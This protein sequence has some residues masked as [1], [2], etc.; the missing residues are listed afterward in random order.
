MHIHMHIMCAYKHERTHTHTHTHILHKRVWVLADLDLQQIQ[1]SGNEHPDDRHCR[2]HRGKRLRAWA[3]EG[4]PGFEG[5]R[6]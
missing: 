4:G 1:A 2:G 3:S 5:P 6:V